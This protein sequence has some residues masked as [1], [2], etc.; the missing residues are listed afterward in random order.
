MICSPMKGMTDIKISC[1]VTS[2]GATYFSQKQA[3]P[4]G[5]ERK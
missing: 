2:F 1:R 5:G 3:G 4:K